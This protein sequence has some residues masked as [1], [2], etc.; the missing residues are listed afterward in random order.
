MRNDLISYIIC[1]IECN[2]S[3][4]ESSNQKDAKFWCFKDYMASYVFAA[5]IKFWDIFFNVAIKHK[6]TFHGFRGAVVVFHG[7][8]QSLWVSQ[9]LGNK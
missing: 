6:K 9:M 2:R 7:G 4:D 3:Y 1:V 5:I 8:M